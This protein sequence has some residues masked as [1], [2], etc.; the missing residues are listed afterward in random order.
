MPVITAIHPSRRGPRLL[1]IEVDGAP[2]GELPA[3]EVESRGL[4]VGQS[5]DEA[6]LSELARG[7]DVAAALVLANSFLAHRP[8]AAAEVRQRLQRAGH[9]DEIVDTAI[10]RLI[11]AG[12]IDDRRFAALWVENRAT[13][14]PRSARALEAE[15]RRKG[16]DRQTAEETLSEA[17]PGDETAA[18]VDAGRRRLRAFSSLDG[19]TFRKRM[20]G[21][22]ARRGFGYEA[23]GA[24]A[25]ILWAEARPE[26]G[27]GQE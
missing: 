12:L 2:L 6:A 5:L 16:I 23:I 22:L 8:R 14:S 4:S 18:A 11:A 7:S 25:D 9:S 3:R 24:A 13:F 15:L 26:S 19:E 10:E 20:G 1:R 17:L 27:A 21:F